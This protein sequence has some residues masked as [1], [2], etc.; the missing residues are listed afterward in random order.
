MADLLKLTIPP[1]QSSYTAEK[2]IAEIL[3]VQLQGGKGRYRRD[4]L[5][6]TF[7]VKCQ[8]KVSGDIFDYLNAHSRVF[9]SQVNPFLIDLFIEEQ[10]LRNVKAWFVPKSFKLSNYDSYNTYTVSAQLEV[11]PPD[12]AIEDDLDLI[13]IVNE[14]GPYYREWLERLERLWKIVNI[15]YP[16]AMPVPPLYP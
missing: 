4:I 15:D 16:V 2:S 14:F 8:W 3:R 5:G 6:A 11:I 12:Y 10:V 13:E 1:D 9:T 7:I